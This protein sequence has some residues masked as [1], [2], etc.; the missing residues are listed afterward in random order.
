[1]KRICAVCATGESARGDGLSRY[2]QIVQNVQ[3]KRERRGE[4]GCP[5]M[6]SLCKGGE[7]T[8]RRRVAPQVYVQYRHQVCVAWYV[9]AEKTDL[10]QRERIWNMFK[11]CRVC[12]GQRLGLWRVCTGG[13]DRARAR[14]QWTFEA[15][16]GHQR[17]C[18]K[19]HCW[20]AIAP[21]CR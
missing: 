20:A 7:S 11:N 2:V 9:Q 14:C 16:D 13:E 15:N 6:C 18:L 4:T 17:L 5:V 10:F 3:K 12:T 1:M 21:W 8:G 19:Q